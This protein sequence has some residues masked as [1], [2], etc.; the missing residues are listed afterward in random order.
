MENTMLEKSWKKKMLGALGAAAL[1]TAPTTV[2]GDGEKVHHII[3]N[4]AEMQHSA[5]L[6]DYSVDFGKHPM[7]KFLAPISFLESSGGKNMSHSTVQGG[8]HAGDSALGKFALMPKTVQNVAS[9]LTHK[10][11]VL[12]NKLGPA[13][14]DPEVAAFRTMPED[15]I[16]TK[17]KN[18]MP[19][20]R[21]IARYLATHLDAIHGGDPYRSAY[22]WR[23]GS[24]KP[25]HSINQKDLD[26]SGYVKKF[27]TLYDKK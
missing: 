17:L 3:H 12:R 2:H 7:D 15:Q 18:N 21:R 6:K 1:T 16:S 13:Y 4:P 5:S 25:S 20:Q 9:M 24:N 14:Q 27:K 11:S 10:G 23:F 26:D 22:G 8:L 19:L